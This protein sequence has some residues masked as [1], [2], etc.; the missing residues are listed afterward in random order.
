M[1]SGIKVGEGVPKEEAS[2]LN[3]KEGPRTIRAHG[4][5]TGRWRTASRKLTVWVSVRGG[6]LG[7]KDTF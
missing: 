7:S 1:E 5:S 4:I 6:G 2:E 3:G